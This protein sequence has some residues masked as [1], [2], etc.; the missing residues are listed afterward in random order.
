[1]LRRG[2]KI[3]SRDLLNE[4]RNRSRKKGNESAL[5]RLI[6]PVGSLPNFADDWPPLTLWFLRLPGDGSARVRNSSSKQ[7]EARGKRAALSADG[8]AAFR[9]RAPVLHATNTLR[10]RKRGVKEKRIIFL[11][12]CAHAIHRGEPSESAALL[13]FNLEVVEVYA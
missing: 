2:S 1:M 5:I 8:P 7:L 13:R 9:D 10:V 12:Y 6:S 3:L 4:R 11:D